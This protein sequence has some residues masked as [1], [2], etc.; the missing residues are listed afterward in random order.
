MGSTMVNNMTQGSLAKRLLRFAVPLILSQ[1]L[2][3]LYSTVDMVI[4]GQYVGA[5]GISAISLGGDLLHIFTN[6]CLG[7]TMG[8]QIL[9]AQHV[10]AGNGDALKRSIGTIFTVLM[11]VSVAF[12]LLSLCTRGLLVD[13]MRTPVE[14]REQTES[15]VLICGLGLPCIYG[16][17]CVSSVLRGMGDSKH[18][19]IFVAI[20]SGV[21]V[22]LDLLLV[23]ACGM[24][25]AGAAIATVIG[26]GVSVVCAVIYLYK[27]RQRF[28]FDFRPESFRVD[29]TE[30]KA[31]MKVGIPLV[32]Q[33]TAINFSMLYIT[34][35]IN[36][37]GVTASAVNGVGNKIQNIGN[38][39][40]TGLN[41]AGGTV[42]GQNLGAGRQD[43]AKKTVYIAF[44]LCMAL[45]CV[46]IAVSTALP[47]ELFSLFTQDPAVIDM[48]PDYMKIQV[49]GFLGGALSGSFGTM[50]TGCGFSTLALCVGLVDGV[51]ARIG[52]GVFMA[53]VLDFGLY[54][55]FYGHALAR[56]VAA[57]IQVGYFASGKWRTRRL[58][59]DRDGK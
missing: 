3:S 40:I 30:L 28:G 37:Y 57:T 29:R 51:I 10:G 38:I 59:V 5:S 15:Y 31:L 55:Y 36:L 23:G 44:G 33:N 35:Q 9:I 16:Y 8:G 48:A 4:V 13:I 6:I 2:Q 47:K 56:V 17:N 24:Q 53:E 49:W 14:S 27:N 11:G 43:R 26:Q 7:L 1:L 25:A 20:A 54:G 41:G 58:L 18:P 21:N 42:I 46:N 32:I 34:A 39:V 45:C 19:L 12:M 52:I 50:I 22:V